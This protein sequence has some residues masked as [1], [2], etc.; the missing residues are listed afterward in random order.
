MTSSPRLL[1]AV[2]G[3]GYGH[4]AQCAPVINALW[5]AI[6]ELRLTVCGALS[7]KVIAARLD[8]GFTFL[9]V[10]LDP[11][12]HMRNACDVDV[13]A[14]RRVYREFHRNRQ[15]GL[16]HDGYLLET[17]APDLVLADIPW[18]VLHAARERNIAAVALCSLNWA[19]I[20][21]ACCGEDAVDAAM[22]G[23]M[24]AG[25]RAARVFLAPE[26]ALPMPALD[27]CRA[28][29]PI[30]R[31]GVQRRDALLARCGLP[32]KTR[33]VLV[34]LGGIPT[35]LPL[36]C[37]PHRE[38]VAW[39]HAGAVGAGRED[40]IDIAATGMEF[41]DVLASCHAVLTK[42]GYGTYTEA[43]CNGVPILTLARPDWPETTYLNAWARRYG[44]LEEI[45]ANQFETGC[46]MTA[47]ES[48]WTR[49]ATPPIEAT[50]IAQAV[51]IIAPCLAQA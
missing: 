36:A 27:N 33:L 26:P 43:V 25:Y 49:P 48:L 10:E 34:A 42:P 22:L 50:G 13:P 21:A 2:S 51:A 18:R 12:L 9:P 14:S 17:L 32:E 46:F 44:R 8:R 20:Y 3:H 16:R 38:D 4:L 19:A 31:R 30:A 1:L 39:L 47:L 6:P 37:W 41:I 23:D 45:S 24:L 5:E 28:I 11:L 40:L 7:R 29:G 15:A 35:G